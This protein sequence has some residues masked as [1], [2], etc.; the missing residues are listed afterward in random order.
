[1]MVSRYFGA[2]DVAQSHWDE[3]IEKPWE[4]PVQYCFDRGLLETFPFTI[5]SASSMFSASNA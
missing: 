1:M 4:V 3:S 5:S 2:D